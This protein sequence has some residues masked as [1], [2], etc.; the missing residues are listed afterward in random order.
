MADFTEVVKWDTSTKLRDNLV[1]GVRNPTLDNILVRREGL[2]PDSKFGR[3]IYRYDF[4]RSGTVTALRFNGAPHVKFRLRVAD[5]TQSLNQQAFEGTERDPFSGTVIDTVKYTVDPHAYTVVQSNGVRVLGIQ[6]GTAGIFDNPARLVVNEPRVGTY[7]VRANMRLTA[8]TDEPRNSGA[9]SFLELDNGTNNIQ[10]Q[11]YFAQIRANIVDAYGNTLGRDV[12]N[13][14][15]ILGE[16]VD[17]RV[18]DTLV[19]TTD[20]LSDG[21]FGS[22]KDIVS[23]PEIEEEFTNLK[24][25]DEV[26]DFLERISLTD[27]CVRV[28]GLR[29]DYSLSGIL[30][31]L[32]SGL[33][34]RPKKINGYFAM[35]I[36]LVGGAGDLFANEILSL[37]LNPETR[38]YEFAEVNDHWTTTVSVPAGTHQYYFIVDG[39]KTL[40]PNN[41]EVVALALGDANVLSV[42]NTQFVEF[43]FDG[44]AKQVYVAFSFEDFN[45][46]INTLEVGFDPSEILKAVTPSQTYFNNHPDWH[47]MEVMF[48]EP[49]P[50][51]GVRLITDV[52]LDQ[53]QRVRILLDD[54]PITKDEWRLFCTPED[55]AD[56]GISECATYSN[57]LQSS[58]QEEC[59]SHYVNN[60]DVITASEDQVVEWELV[61][62]EPILNREIKTYSKFTFMSRLENQ[63]LFQRAHRSIEI[64]LPAEAVTKVTDF[65]VSDDALPFRSSRRTQVGPEGQWTIEQ[66]AIEDGTTTLVPI[67]DLAGAVTYGDSVNVVREGLQSFIEPLNQSGIALNNAEVACTLATN[68]T[69]P[70]EEVLSIIDLGPDG[71][72]YGPDPDQRFTRES[73]TR[74]TDRRRVAVINIDLEPVGVYYLH[75][76][77][78]PT[79]FRLEVY[80]TAEDARNRTNSLGFAVSSG[81]GF[82]ILTGFMPEDPVET[83]T[84]LINLTADNIIVCFDENAANS[85]FETTPRVNV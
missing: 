49:L 62:D 59:F 40:D 83:E 70:L 42:P 37:N 31:D 35:R 73:F 11:K 9:V 55:V 72:P 71:S 47:K 64:L 36:P 80:A 56:P 24:V 78:Q 23:S 12:S 8:D 38:E 43:S 33:F 65:L 25:V 3:A 53:R 52:P 58:A 18:N 34:Y 44:K 32:Q 79:N 7:S 26:V 4:G 30:A 50:I 28:T 10:V 74:A 1:Y 61:V 13:N 2:I 27:T 77:G 5:T 84:G 22:I 6:A 63:A 48:N 39:E 17:I 85:I 57:L 75:L 20:I 51:V 69:Q 21:S 19:D 29:A 41:G 81:Y 16:P 82:Q 46:T 66:T 15:I 67:Q 68:L 45:E 76:I 60:T 14:D 54:A